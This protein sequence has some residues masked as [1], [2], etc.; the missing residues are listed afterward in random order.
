MLLDET[1]QRL[2]DMRLHDLDFRGARFVG[3]RKFEDAGTHRRHLRQR[4]R[5]DRRDD[6]SAERGLER[7]QAILLVDLQPDRVAGQTKSQAGRESRT[8]V[9]SA[10]GC[11]EKKSPRLALLD[12][13]SYS[14]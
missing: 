4:L 7:D 13:R 3:I 9:A 12:H 2:R 1:A 11:G 6:V 10:L 14:F 5:E 8:P